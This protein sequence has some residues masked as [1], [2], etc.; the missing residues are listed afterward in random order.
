MNICSLCTY[1]SQYLLF[2]KI[3]YSNIYYLL[4]IYPLKGIG[5]MTK[6]AWKYSLGVLLTI[7]CSVLWAT[8]KAPNNSAPI[9]AI[10]MQEKQ[11][12]LTPKQALAKLKDG[13]QRFLTNQLRQKNYLAQAK[14]ASYGQFPWAVILNCMDSRSVPEFLFDQGLADLFTLRV[15]GNVLNDDILGSIEYATQIVGAKLIVV[16]GHTSCGAVDGACKDIKLGHLND[17]FTKIKPAV[18]PAKKETGLKD[19]NNP[20]LINKIAEINA[21]QV[22][23]QIRDNSPIVYDLIKKGEIGIVAA[24]HN[25]KTGEVVFFEIKV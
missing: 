21:L 7:I 10:S 25:I 8:D 5:Q 17:V 15:A 14:E 6:L 1:N 9:T 23:N 13:N 2:K 4:F 20:S 3:C 24:M 11:I 12:N 18:E 22:A 16:M 19:C